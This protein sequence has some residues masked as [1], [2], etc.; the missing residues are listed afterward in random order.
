MTT[1]RLF[2]TTLRIQPQLNS[3][4]WAWYHSAQACAF[5]SIMSSWAFSILT[6]N[7]DGMEN[8][9]HSGQNRMTPLHPGRN[10]MNSP[11][12]PKW[13]CHSIPARMEWL[14]SI[15]ARTERALHS[16]RIGHSNPAG[17][18][19]HSFDNLKKYAYW[20]PI[21]NLRPRADRCFYP[22]AETGKILHEE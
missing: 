17:L 15:P 5:Y 13:N 18:E 7:P 3:N 19:C 6:N 1:S 14:H 20:L 21:T 12:R 22:H 10:G 8:S 16:D 2:K 4:Y 11:F 9:F